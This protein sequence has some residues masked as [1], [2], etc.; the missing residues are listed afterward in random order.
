MEALDL[1]A[2]RLLHL[3]DAFTAAAD[4][5]HATVDQYAQ[6]DD[7]EGPHPVRDDD[8]QAHRPQQPGPHRGREAGH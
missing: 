2:K 8:E 6:R 3:R 5:A 7:A 4:R 1:T